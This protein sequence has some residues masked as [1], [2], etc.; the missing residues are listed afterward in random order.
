M[1]FWVSVCSAPAGAN[2]LAAARDF[3]TPVARFE[4]RECNFT[5]LH[6]FNGQLFQAQQV[7]RAT[8]GPFRAMRRVLVARFPRLTSA[9]QHPCWP[10]YLMRRTVLRVE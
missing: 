5:V 8:A 9:L 7:R 3:L 10:A 2:G 1:V 4:E 6:K